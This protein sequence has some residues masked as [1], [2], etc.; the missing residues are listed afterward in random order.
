MAMLNNQ[1]VKQTCPRAQGACRFWKR[2]LLYSYQTQQD[3][4]SI[5]W[6]RKE[7]PW[8]LGHTSDM[9]MCPATAGKGNSIENHVF[10]MKLRDF[11]HFVASKICSHQLWGLSLWERQHTSAPAMQDLCHP[12]M[13]NKHCMWEYVGSLHSEL[14][15]SSMF[16]N[17]STT[18]HFLVWPKCDYGTWRV[19]TLANLAW[20]GHF[21]GF[22]SWWSSGST[23]NHR[24]RGK[25]TRTL[26]YS[27]CFHHNFAFCTKMRDLYRLITWYFPVPNVSPNLV[28]EA[29]L[30]HAQHSHPAARQPWKAHLLVVAG[31]CSRK[32]HLKFQR[33]PKFPIDMTILWG[34]YHF[35]MHPRR[36]CVKCAFKTWKHTTRKKRWKSGMRC[37]FSR[38]VRGR[39]L[40]RPS[41]GLDRLRCAKS[42]ST[43][44]WSADQQ[45]SVLCSFLKPPENWRR[46]TAPM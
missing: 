19:P 37:S 43:A 1:R 46:R 10:S 17:A 14:C 7:R 35:Q 2:F 18:L 12:R 44:Q 22:S 34:T 39:H 25:K 45:P 13:E 26:I 21:A 42:R 6:H 27:W 29:P 11:L 9:P 24:G 20:Y 28:G 41:G 16:L 33:I 8:A 23:V 40:V 15:V 3:V 36:S 4:P 38:F 5:T 31:F 30:R 32:W